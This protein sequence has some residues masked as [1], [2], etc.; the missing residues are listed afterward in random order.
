MLPQGLETDYYEKN[1]KYKFVYVNG[2]RQCLAN[3]G[4]HESLAAGPAVS[5]VPK[6]LDKY[7]YAGVELVDGRND[8]YRAGG[9]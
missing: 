6:D 7:T 5:V 2:E 4:P 3:E 1:S 8:K 9:R